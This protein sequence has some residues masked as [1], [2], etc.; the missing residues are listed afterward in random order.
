MMRYA[1][2]SGKLKSVVVSGFSWFA[3]SPTET[4]L[5]AQLLWHIADGYESRID[6]GLIG[7]EQDF[8]T[9]IVGG[10]HEADELVF[11]KSI[12]SGR[13]WMKVPSFA[14]AHGRSNRQHIVPCNYEDYQ[15]A[16]LGELP[17][18]WWRTHQ[19]LV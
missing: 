1:G 4:A 12:R 6:D 15:Q 13:W 5:I 11:Y 8:L 19:K 14:K 7:K 16:M 18:T 9:Y 17:D 2:H 3:L 10:A